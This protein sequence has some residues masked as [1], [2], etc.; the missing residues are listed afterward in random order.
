MN[1][2]GASLRDEELN[3]KQLDNEAAATQPEDEAGF[4][5]II[6]K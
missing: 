4:N 5:F 2:R 1:Q 3:A 6:I